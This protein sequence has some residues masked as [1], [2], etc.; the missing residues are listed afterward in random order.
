MRALFKSFLF[1]L[2]CQLA[3]YATYSQSARFTNAKSWVN[4][5]DLDVS[6]NQITVEAL[7][8]TD[9]VPTL[10][11]N[12]VSKHTG[13]SNVNYLIRPLTFEITT[14]LSGNSGPTQFLQLYNPIQLQ[15]GKWYH[16]A[17]TYDGSTV[18]YY[19]NGCLVASAAFSGELYQNDFLTGIGNTSDPNLQEQVYGKIDEVRIWNVARTEAEISANMMN[20]PAP[21]TQLGLMA[22]YKMS[23]DFLNLQGNAIYNGVSVN[24]VGFAT[25]DGVVVP[26]TITSYNSTNASCSKGADG[27]IT[28]TT[29][30]LGCSFS[31]DGLF[32]QSSNVLTG[33]NPGTYTV[34]VKT[35][36]GCILT[37]PPIT[38]G[39]NNL[40]NINAIDSTICEGTSLFGYSLPGLYRD[41]LIST[42][43]CDVIR[44][45]NLKNKVSPKTNIVITLC[46]GQNYQG[47]TNSGTYVNVFPAANGCDS[48]RTL[49]LTVLKR[50]YSAFTVSICP[51]DNY[52]GY[53]KAGTY[54]DTFVNAQGCDSVRTINLSLKQ[55]TFS[56][57]AKSI[58]RG[59]S[60]LGYSIAGV[61]NDTLVN[62]EGCDSVRTLTL[63]YT[64]PIKPSLGPDRE[65]CT[66]DTLVLNPGN[67]T[68]YTWQDNS[69]AATFVV[70]VGGTYSVTVQ[71]NCGLETD[72]IT[73]KEVLCKLMF[74]N[75]FTPNNDG[76]NDVFKALN[77]F[78]IQSYRLQIFNRW[79][80]KVFETTDVSKGWDGKINGYIQATNTYAYKCIFNRD[81]KISEL[82]GS[83]V[84]I[85]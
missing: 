5:G 21:T 63:S 70:K 15:V 1:L 32:Y 69:T 3:A 8:Y 79:G 26:V 73:I 10:P 47:Y 41:T 85:K 38:V 14:Y 49:Q 66:F 4:I 2:F 24:G 27:T 36:G 51:G 56:S 35:P 7:Y 77:T 75:A 58:C 31:L 81:G 84:L 50:T 64:T 43:G 44:I 20:L 53:D 40:Y 78:G 52:L 13:P 19:L 82:H 48:T 45:L 33:L 6:G 80:Q 46:E 29:S 71:S 57:I 39:N 34:F 65:L 67:F 59:E 83:F 60:Y 62:A 22:Y 72:E 55:R 9:V 28:V 18:K 30:E 42:F 23:N 17:G 37:T 54:R 68:S 16:I 74:P 61:Y 25:D 11:M 12:I 76:K